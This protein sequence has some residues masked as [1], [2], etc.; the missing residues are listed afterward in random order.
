MMMFPGGV[1][2]PEPLAL[3]LAA[4][5]G[6]LI[7]SFLNVVI[8]R[9]P[10]MLE[11]GWSEQCAELAREQAAQAGK[12]LPEPVQAETYDLIRPASSCPACGHRIRWFE[13]IPV[14]SWLM[15]RGR[16]SACGT[17]I[18]LRYPAIELLTALL[19]ALSLWV[20]GP[21]LKAL[22]AMVFCALMIAMAFI[23]ADTTLLPDDLT[24]P[25]LW[26]GLLLNLGGVFAP[27]DQ[28]VIGAMAGYLSLWLVYW[29]FKLLTGK[30]GMGFGDFKLFAAIGAWF[31]WTVLPM[32]ILL[33]SL[34]GAV[35]GLAILA[36][37]RL[38]RGHALPFG[39]YLAVAG[40][41]V[42]FAGDTLQRWIFPF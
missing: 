34:A 30:E 28:A 10:R 37:R 9:L 21:T 2:L 26:L 16:C 14:V 19:F 23:D 18:S 17:A 6:L 24:L 42:L 29:G 35:I 33:S 8:H 39:P 1:A 40:V 41:L 15:L 5:L 11:R 20:F 31:G 7:G 13:N 22:A 4:L 25:L 3:G 36:W 32:V 27:L 12:P 38:G